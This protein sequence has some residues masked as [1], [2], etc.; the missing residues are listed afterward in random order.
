MFI[1]GLSERID[2][3][4]KAF[5][6]RN[7]TT[8]SGI[9]HQLKGAAGG[10]GYPSLSEL[11]FKVEHLAKQNADDA[12]IE[13]ALD[14]LISQC[15]GAIAGVRGSESLSPTTKPVDATVATESGS[16][17]SSEETAT[18]DEQTTTLETIHQEVP[19]VAQ[20]AVAELASDNPLADIAAQLEKLND[21]DVDSQQLSAALKS[22][23]QVLGTTAN[24]TASSTE[25][26]S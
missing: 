13:D 18:S 17:V 9:A 3:I 24:S 15:R 25:P 20:S 7:F 26:V 8:V 4:L 16:P 1:D 23:A 10:Y 2:S 6:D 19:E 12:L 22:L 5:D 11:A 14:L 21:P